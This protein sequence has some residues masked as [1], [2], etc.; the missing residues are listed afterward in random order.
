VARLPII[1]AAANAALYV[2]E[3]RTL[4][5]WIH[6]RDL[7]M[8]VTTG[9]LVGTTSL[10]LFLSA[11]GIYSLMSVTVSR[12]TREIGLR[13]ALGAR[14]RDVLASTLSRAAVLI[15]SGVFA[16]GFLLLLFVAVS[17]DDVAL[18]AGFLAATTGVM[19]VAALLASIVPAR[20]ALRISPIDALRDS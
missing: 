19:L 11:L 8:L 10:V 16:G 4:G 18:Y 3:A 14:P 2:Q 6:R 12:R 5:D 15:G 9:A 20:R 13:A 7:N 1:A 17:R